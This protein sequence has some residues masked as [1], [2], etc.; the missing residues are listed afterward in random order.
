MS[1]LENVLYKCFL[2]SLT[3]WFQSLKFEVSVAEPGLMNLKP[4]LGPS[5]VLFPQ[6]HA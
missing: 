4:R 3:T 2:R 5:H 1:P 6:F